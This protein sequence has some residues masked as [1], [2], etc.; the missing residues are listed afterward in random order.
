M[1]TKQ[2]KVVSP[3]EVRRLLDHVTHSRHPE[4]NRVMVLLSFKAGLRA[5][6]IAGLRWSMLTDASGELTDCIALPNRVAKGKSGGRTIPMHPELREAL[7]ALSEARP[8]KVRPDW[9]IAYSERG[10]FSAN[11]VAVWFWE[12][13]REIGL[14]GASSHSGRRTFV[15]AAAKK[16]VEAGGSLRD[17]QEL[18]GHTS[19][20]TTQRYIQGDALA[21]RKVIELI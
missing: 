19:L 9:P 13:F 3:R 6:E 2:A 15:T 1:L 10:G 7:A 5:V 14:E 4:R 16:I 11:S 17:V 8:D 18:A 12:R 21:K 20:A